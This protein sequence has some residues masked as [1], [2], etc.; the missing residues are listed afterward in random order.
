MAGDLLQLMAGA[1]E[2]FKDRCKVSAGERPV[3][4]IEVDGS[5]WHGGELGREP[6]LPGIGLERWELETQAR[7]WNGIDVHGRTL[8][9]FAGPRACWRG[10]RAV[11]Q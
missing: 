11:R 7:L 2:N 5:N 10:L 9:R 6:L 8:D 4:G 1:F 3:A